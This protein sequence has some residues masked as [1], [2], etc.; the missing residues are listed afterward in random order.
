MTRSAILLCL[1]LSGWASLVYQIVWTRL[2]G[3]AFG[4]TTEAI[5]AVL[6][7]F[8]AGLA[9]GGWI[10][11]RALPRVRRPL[12]LYA[13]LE[14][15]IGAF[16][17]ASLPCLR[18]LDELYAWIGT[19]HG[20]GVLAAIRVAAAAAVLLP[21]TLAMGATLP[22]VAAGMLTSS[23]SLG[24]GSALLYAGNTAGAVLG[25]YLCGFWMI[26]GL[27]LAWS[28]LAAALGNLAAA[29][30]AFVLAGRA[31]ALAPAPIEAPRASSGDEASAR[32]SASRATRQSFLALFAV[33]GFVAIGYEM[34]WS[35]LFGIVMEGTLYGFAAVL[36]S[37]LLGIALGSFAIA[38]HV[39]RLRD[40]PRAFGLLHLAIAVSVAA[41]VQAVPLL[42]H[43]HRWLL[44]S[45]AGAD[46][47][48]LLFLLV[49]PIVLVP[50]A[51]FGAAFPVLIRIQARSAREAGAGIGIAGAVNTAG[52][53]A[54]SLLLGFW[55]LPALGMDA[56]LYALCLADLGIALLVLLGFQTSRGQA[57]L[58]TSGLATLFLLAF[59]VSWNGV[60]VE[61]AIAGR[62]LP[63]SGFGQYVRELEHR[64]ES[65][66][67]LVE[68][69]SSIVAVYATP[70]ARVL[71]ANGLPE[72]RLQLRPPYYPLET[73]LLGLLPQLF[74]EGGERALVIGLGG[75][76]TLTALARTTLREIDV[77]ELEPAVASA[78][79]TLHAGWPNPLD[80]PRVRLSIN[81]GRNELLLGRHRGARFDVIA[82]QPSHPWLQGAAN[83]FTEEFFA[84]ARENLSEGGVFACWVNGFRTDP[85]SLLALVAGFERVFPG[86]WLASGVRDASRSSLLLLGGRRPLH[87][88]VERARLRLAEPGVSEIL[89]LFGI[90]GLEE[91]LAQLEGPASAF[92][93]LEPG[94]SNTD[95]NAFVETRIPRRFDWRDLDFAAIESRL[96]RDAPVLPPLSRPVDVEQVGLALSRGSQAVRAG[97]ASKLERLVH[98]HAARLDEVT[99]GTL[100]ARARLASDRTQAGAIAELRRLG[101]AH[102][103]SPAP[104]RAL[105]EHYARSGRRHPE[106]ATAFAEAFARS[107]DLRDAFDAGHA[108]HAVDPGGARRWFA[109]IPAA[110]RH[111]FPGLAVYDAAAAL[112]REA[113]PEE[114][115]LHLDAVLRYR[116]TEEGRGVQGLAAFVAELSRAAGDEAAAR[117]FAD[118]DH[119]ERLARARVGLRA[120][121]RALAKGDA[122]AA[123]AALDAAAALVPG[124]PRVAELRARAAL[125][126]GDRAGTEAA[127]AALRA[128]APTLA[129]AVAAENRFRAEHGLPLL[130]DRPAALLVGPAP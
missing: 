33:S 105:G 97:L 45:L 24:R 113:A 81:D 12:R 83:L 123:L 74:A 19:Q 13:L 54:A 59:A 38:R 20:P 1:L 130:P 82:S 107:G 65:R 79:R 85:E 35:R 11:A 36:S 71:L 42:P 90:Q 95:D 118:A 44:R 53:I 89:A 76:N 69:R 128:S 25:A 96:P 104:F 40:L 48:H 78:V 100:L 34:V 122:G 18:E 106:V 92:A 112:A 41:G 30:T 98:A 86:S 8:F 23:A 101:E 77:V 62:D 94:A 60:R 16:A 26:P 56:T 29:A 129:E 108:L 68:G 28:V 114:L 27:G 9:G 7:V 103:R 10:A 117:S 17:L 2:L 87:L 52:S 31:G 50:T 109:R 37:F 61:R 66:V 39:D 55:A 22:V 80:D 63:P 57:R 6:A 99:R 126:R 46:G 47:L 75:G 64:D 21:P 84:L 127:L 91:L 14:I 115:A 116:D 88:D 3:L 43:A 70:E 49:L 72:S 102:P 124:D 15:G 121:E 32:G 93:A 67:L 5:G 111:R 51:L 58:A 120:S 4:T 125:A 119:R 110:E 73:V